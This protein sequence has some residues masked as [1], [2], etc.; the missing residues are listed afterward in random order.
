MKI[1]Y[2]PSSRG[3]Y[4]DY[5]HESNIPED[6]IEISQDLYSFLLEQ[7][8]QGK[9]IQPGISGLPEAVD[10]PEPSFEELVS[11]YTGLIQKRLD[12]FAKTRNYDN[13]LSACTYAT[14]T[15]PKFQAE[16]QYC[17]DA[18]DATWNTCYEILAEVQA[19]T[20]PMPTFEEIEAELPVL[21][22]PA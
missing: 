7:Q 8:S 16:A 10:P 11:Q 4:N 6:A 21:A 9:I 2:S 19:Q 17:V 20:R 12:D 15:V 3:F 22:W 14:S 1:Y 5:I 13:I 18:R